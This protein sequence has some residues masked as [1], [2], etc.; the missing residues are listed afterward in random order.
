MK[1]HWNGKEIDSLML[2]LRKKTENFAPPMSFSIIHIFGKDP[3]LILIS[4]LLSLRARDSM[5]LPVSVQLFE[6]T[7]T[8]QDFLTLPLSELEQAIYS[9]GFY[10]RKALQ[11]KKVSQVLLDDY[12]GVVPSTQEELLKLPGVG[13]KTANLVLSVAFDIPALC[14][15]VHVHR[16]SNRLGLVQTKTPE[17]TEKEL[18]KVLP[19]KYWSEWNALLVMWGQNVCPRSQEC[20]LCDAAQ[21]RKKRVIKNR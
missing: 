20:G 21:L 3:F 13:I 12:K 6:H 8:P 17:Q 7:R 19:K 2:R 1:R 16:I 15:D 14:V 9:I 5:T 18:Q 11:L 4:C 10:K